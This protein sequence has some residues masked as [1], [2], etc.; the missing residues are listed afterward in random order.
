MPRSPVSRQAPKQPN[1]HG[2]ASLVGHLAAILTHVDNLAQRL[3]ITLASI[4]T[5]TVLTLVSLYFMRDSVAGVVA[6]YLIAIV[7]TIF[8]RWKRLDQS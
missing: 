6:I 5:L 7:A 3:G 8:A 1:S 4:I 2:S